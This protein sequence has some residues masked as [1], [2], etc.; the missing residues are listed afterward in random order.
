MMIWILA[1]QQQSMQQLPAGEGSFQLL[2]Q[3]SNVLQKIASFARH[4]ILHCLQ[5]D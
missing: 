3:K 5:T 2:K 4:L 1:R